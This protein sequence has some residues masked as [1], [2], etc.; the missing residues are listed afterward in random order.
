MTLHKY[1]LATCA[2][3]IVSLSLAHICIAQEDLEIEEEKVEQ[4]E[5]LFSDVHLGHPEYR[6]IKYL[7]DSGIINGY[8]DGSF[9][10]DNY[11]NRIEALKI[12]MEANDLIN[13]SYIEENKLGGSEFKEVSELVTF[14]D[15]YKSHWYYPYLKKAVKDDIVN[16]YPDNTF[17][18]T[19]IVNRAESYKITMESDGVKLPEVTEDPFADVP[20]GE[21]FAPYFLEAKNR[22]IVY[23]TMQNLVNPA[24]EMKRSRFAEL[25]YRYIK[26]KEGNKFGKGSFYSDYFEGRRTASGEQYTG[27]ELTA[28]HLSLP[29]DTVVKVTNLANN[30]SVT[31]RINDRGPYV[32]GRVIDLSKSAF[33]EIAH[34]GEGLI[35]VEYEIINAE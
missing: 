2:I 34:L 27:T 16:G 18:P 12:I 29:F 26:S 31:V 5:Q 9:K 17:R 23:I 24:R 32:T 10:P 4:E 11:I 33:N 30:N 20:A 15:I 14:T 35:Y 13:S 22:E 19:K 1:I 8:P 7:R 6:A 25:V 3:T 28:A 21:W